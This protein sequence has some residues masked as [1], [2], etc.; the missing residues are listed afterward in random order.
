VTTGTETAFHAA[1]E[2]AAEALRDGLP[3]AFEASPA[4]DRP[5][6]LVAPGDGAVAVVAGIAGGDGAVL[7]LALAADVVAAVVD[8][9]LGE[10]E[11]GAALVPALEGALGALE[12]ALGTGLALDAPQAVAADLAI[13]SLARSGSPTFAVTLQIA[14]GPA[15]LFVLGAPMPELALE[16]I[17][18]DGDVGAGPLREVDASSLDLLGDVEMSVTA[19]LG[20]TRLSVRHL[21]GLAVGHVVELDRTADSA[22]DLLVNGTLV[23]RGE[24]V[25][26]DDEFGVRITE[27]VGR[28][29]RPQR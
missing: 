19:V 7:V 22:V 28:R 20:R 14:G 1:A 2:A 27:I 6:A 24:V 18:G 21:L 13:E 16:P 8:G 11:L 17:L 25:V 4:D 3:F 15:G 9:P 5:E 12:P 26:I 29:E 23:A 10:Q